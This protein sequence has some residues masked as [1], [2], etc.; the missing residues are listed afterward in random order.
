MT[1][2]HCGL[3]FRATAL[4]PRVTSYHYLAQMNVPLTHQVRMMFTLST[5][6]GQIYDLLVHKTQAQKQI[7]AVQ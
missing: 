1:D 4:P 7:T 2:V 3:S 6:K 5:H